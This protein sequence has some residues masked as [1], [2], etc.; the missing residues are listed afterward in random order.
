[1]ARVLSN[2]ATLECA[3]ETALGTLPSSGWRLL[4][5]NR[6][7][8]GPAI[9]KVYRDI[10]SKSRRKR[11]GQITDVKS[12]VTVDADITMELMDEFVESAVMASSTWALNTRRWV[13]TAVTSVAFVVPSGGALAQYT[14]VKAK[15]F[16]V[17]GNNGLFVVGAASDADEIKCSG[18]TAEA[19]IPAAQNVTLQICG[20]QGTA[21]DITMDA[22]GRL[23]STV[24]NFTTLG[25]TVGQMIKIGGA[26]AGLQ[27]ATAANNGYARITAIAAGLL[28]LDR[29]SATF[30]IDSGATKTIQIFF[31]GFLRDVAVDHGDYIGPE[32][33]AIRSYTFEGLYENLG[34]AEDQFEY[35]RGNVLSML[36][37]SLPLADKATAT[38]DF[39]G[40]DTDAP[41]GEASRA[42]LASAPRVPVEVAMVNTSS[43]VARLIVAEADETGLSTDFKSLSFKFNHNVAPE[44]VLGTLGG[45]YMNC[46]DFD[47]TAEMS[48]LFSNPDVLAA[49]RANDTVGMWWALKNDDGGFGVDVPAMCL[50]SATKE[51]PENASMTL[52]LTGMAIESATYGHLVSVSMFPHL[53]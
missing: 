29:R 17:A 39:V 44:Q 41:V 38:L 20:V 9:A 7:Q 47:V 2:N 50:E 1:M 3:R 5:P 43:D 34:V 49:V 12:A 6:F 36:T 22:S 15:G 18:L 24:L 31:G 46:G 33:S 52:S 37:L 13:P 35:A 27:F 14:L 4:Q 26:S 8:M 45:A 16:A 25:L 19:A 11:K 21:G 10:I 42:T 51:M 28:T 40:T 23:T 30:V 48:L 32:V 53:P